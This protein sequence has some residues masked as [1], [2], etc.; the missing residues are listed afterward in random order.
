MKII[1]HS[2]ESCSVENTYEY[3]CPCLVCVKQT[4]Q[5]ILYTCECNIS[6]F[7][8]VYIQLVVTVT[9]TAAVVTF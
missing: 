4:S 2:M 9:Q 1:T 7:V 5:R 3:A 6:I 8:T